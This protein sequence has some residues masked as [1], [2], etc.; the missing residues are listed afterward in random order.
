MK[1][2][3]IALGTALALASLA[4]GAAAPTATTV[5][6]LAFNDFH[7]QLESP[8]KFD[9]KVVGGVD[10][11]AGYFADRKAANPHTTVV[12]AGD[13]IGATP[14][15]SALF[16]DEP[17]IEAMSM[18]G[19]EFN[20]VGNH[21]FDEGKT[22]L[23]RMQKG[24]CHPTDPNSCKGQF[25]GAPVRDNGDF[26]GAK[27]KFLTANVVENSTGKTVFA[28]YAIKHYGKARV[29]FVGLTLKEAPTIVTPSGVA[30]LTFKDEA[31]SVNALVP[32]LRARGIEAIVVLIHQGGSQP[33]LQNATTMNQC[34]GNLDG[35]V[36]KPIVN[37]LDDAVDLVISGHTHSAY[38]CLVANKAGRQIPVTSAN[39]IGRILTDIDLTIDNKTGH[40][41]HVVAQNV[42]VDQ[43]NAAITPNAEIKAVVDGYKA[44]A[45]PIANRVIGHISSDISRAPTAAGESAL[46][47]VIADA[48]LAATSQTGFGEAV[49][50]FM[51]PGGIRADFTYAGSSAGEGDGQVTYG[52]AFT[53]QPFGNSLV[54]KTLSGQQ[55]H[56]LLNQQW[57]VGQSASGRILQ[58]S[59]GFSYKHTF[60]PGVSP[61]GGNYLCDGSVMLA[62]AP[63]DKAA[64]YRVTMNSFL[65]TGGDNF[66]VFNLGTDQ[67]GGDVDLD[68]LA[69]WFAVRAPAAPTPLDRIQKVASCN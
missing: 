60:T 45:Q 15:L 20:A 67:L 36:L 66:S 19:L 29:A 46:G 11:M 32:K 18:A 44:L 17:T 26:A 30:G 22:E 8:G 43:G 13:L 2:K 59:E 49:A 7:G 23:L 48:Q 12:S 58:V 40:V 28:P 69:A 27:F 38:N 4:A 50:A 16:H 1:L 24:G 25:V 65:A 55:I 37:A 47:D 54:V 21:E 61:L 62:G 56:D 34:N 33:V 14:L 63:I 3:Q 53:V 35:S 31:A 52:E 9:G 41:T 39:S 64:R 5:K 10:W 57:A 42:L 68:A 51:N 6:L